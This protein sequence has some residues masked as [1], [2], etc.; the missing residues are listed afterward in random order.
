MLFN[1]FKYLIIYII[2]SHIINILFFIT[3]IYY[4]FAGRKEKNRIVQLNK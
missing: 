2:I 4:S 1:K 3:K